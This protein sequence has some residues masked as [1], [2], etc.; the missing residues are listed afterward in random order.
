MMFMIFRTNDFYKFKCD[1]CKKNE[2]KFCS[3]SNTYTKV[4][5]LLVHENWTVIVRTNKQGNKFFYYCPECS[6]LK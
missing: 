5:N 2:I 4:L 6:A 3:K 1:E